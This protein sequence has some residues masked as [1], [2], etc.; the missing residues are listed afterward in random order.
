MVELQMRMRERMRVMVL[1]GA[2]GTAGA[3]GTDGWLVMVV[4]RVS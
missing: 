3:D 2:D 4:C 1:M